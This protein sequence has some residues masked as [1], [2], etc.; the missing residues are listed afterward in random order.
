MRANFSYLQWGFLATNQNFVFYVA[1]S[2]DSGSKSCIETWVKLEFERTSMATCGYIFF[3][4]IPDYQYYFQ[5]TKKLNQGCHFLELCRLV[6]LVLEPKAHLVLSGH[7]SF[8]RGSYRVKQQ[9]ILVLNVF[10]CFLHFIQKKILTQI[11]EHLAILLL[12]VIKLCA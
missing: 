2:Q 12:I 1:G 9:E 8:L 5:L 3:I 6:P 7:L 10:I 4:F 11:L